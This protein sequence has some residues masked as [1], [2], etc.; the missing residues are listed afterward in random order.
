MISTCYFHRFQAIRFS[1]FSHGWKV[2]RCRI[3]TRVRSNAKPE[4]LPQLLKFHNATIDVC[5]NLTSKTS[6]FCSY[7]SQHQKHWNVSS[8]PACMQWVPSSSTLR[9]ILQDIDI[10]LQ[11]GR[12]WA[13]SVASFRERLLDFRSCW[14]VFIY[15]VRGRPGGLLQ[16]SKG[17]AVKIFLA[18][19]FAR[20]V[21]RPSGWGVQKGIIPQNGA[22]SVEGHFE[23]N[24]LRK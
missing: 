21:R 2:H 11:S 23:L 18:S 10:S 12:F 17:H 5:Q 9:A 13:T 22:K 14:I 15:V 1:S 24:F 16:F 8:L 3:N 4:N 7:W 20:V 6:E 19:V